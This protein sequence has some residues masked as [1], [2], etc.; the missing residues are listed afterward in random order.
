MAIC[1]KQ[2][3]SNILNS[4]HKKLSNSEAELKKSVDYNKKR[5][6]TGNAFSCN[7]FRK[8]PVSSFSTLV[9]IIV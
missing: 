7:Y 4:I 1:V 5:V 9:G 6:V 2:H 3:L 8:W